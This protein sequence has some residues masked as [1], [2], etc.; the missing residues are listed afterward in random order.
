MQPTTIVRRAMYAAG[1][2]KWGVFTNQYE[3]C[4]TVKMYGEDDAFNQSVIDAI[5]AL[6]IPGLTVKVLP[7]KRVY[8]GYG[9]FRP[10]IIARIPR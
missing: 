4:R 9:T 5:L 10:S 8:G 1:A 2:S 3:K 6:N 7:S